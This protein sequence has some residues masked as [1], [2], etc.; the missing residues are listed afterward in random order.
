MLDNQTRV[1]IPR[2]ENTKLPVVQKKKITQ[3]NK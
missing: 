2:I 3:K 1:F